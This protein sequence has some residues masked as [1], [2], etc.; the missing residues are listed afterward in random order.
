M[1]FGLNKLAQFYR[2]DCRA[3]V[4]AALLAG[5]YECSIRD[6]SFSL[7]G[8][9]NGSYSERAW[10]AQ[11]C[12]LPLHSPFLKLQVKA[13]LQL[14]TACSGKREVTD[15]LKNDNATLAGQYKPLFLI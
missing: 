5:Y 6:L 4:F 3:F 15:M 2:M 14:A 13:V 12:L 11:T 8:K 7:M 10:L 1:G 9:L